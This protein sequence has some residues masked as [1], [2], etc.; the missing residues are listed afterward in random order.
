MMRGKLI[1]ELSID[2]VLMCNELGESKVSQEI[3][4][5]RFVMSMIFFKIPPSCTLFVNNF[6]DHKI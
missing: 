6:L 3:S 1:R 2:Q 5:E 4:K